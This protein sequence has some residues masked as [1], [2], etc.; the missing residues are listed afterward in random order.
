MEKPVQKNASNL[1]RVLKLIVFAISRW[2]Q[3][4]S[5]DLK[6]FFTPIDKYL[7]MPIKNFNFLNCLKEDSFFNFFLIDFK[8]YLFT[9]KT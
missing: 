9:K 2:R 3:K 7:E 6:F 5:A 8:I 4:L 1:N